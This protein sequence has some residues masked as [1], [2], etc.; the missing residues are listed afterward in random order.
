MVGAH[1]AQQRE[2]A[3]VQRRGRAAHDRRRAPRR[4][5]AALRSASSGSIARR[6]VL[7]AERPAMIARA[8]SGST[9]AQRLLDGDRRALAR[10]I[11]LVEDD[12]P[13]GWELVKEVYP[14]TGK[15]AV[16]GFTGPAGR[17]QVDADRR[18]HEGPARGRADGRR[19]VDRPLLAVHPRRAARRP[20]PPR[21][22]T[23]STRACSSA[24]WPTAARSAGSPR[25]RCRPRCC[26]TRPGARTCSS[27]PSASGRRR[28]TSSTTPTRSCSC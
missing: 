12:R 23:S 10:A 20:D 13:E 2:R 28:S 25:P 15:A 3:A 1:E 11:T 16:V 27:R 21:P 4:R 22:S 7:P 18:A 17:G 14:H 9:L 8:M 24:R 26:S 19:A 6:I 5:S